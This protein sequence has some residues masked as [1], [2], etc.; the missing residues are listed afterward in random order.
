MALKVPG[1]ILASDLDDKMDAITPYLF[2]FTDDVDPDVDT[3]IGDIY[4]PVDAA[5]YVQ[6]MTGRVPASVTAGVA[7][8]VWDPVVFTNTTG[9]SQIVYGYGVCD[10]GATVLYWAERN[11]IAPVTVPN[12]ATYTVLPYYE[13]E[14]E[15]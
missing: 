12:G 9:M 11:L 10:S 7:S 14:N 3:V 6:A 4:P 5:F 15:P 1:A 2:L 8:T 13:R